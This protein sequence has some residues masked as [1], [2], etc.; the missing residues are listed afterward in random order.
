M[1]SKSRMV[2]AGI[3]R[4]V[5]KRR[6]GHLS[7][8]DVDYVSEEVMEK[9]YLMFCMDRILKRLYQRGTLEL[10]EQD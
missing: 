3:P 5:A 8:A 2:E 6:I 4:E 9:K 10:Q 1:T 7:G